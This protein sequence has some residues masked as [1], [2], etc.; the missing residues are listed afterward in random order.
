M[1]RK[2]L[3]TGITAFVIGAL[4]TTSLT[5]QQRKDD[6]LR[7]MDEFIAVY[8]K[9]RANYVDKVDDEQLMKGAIQGMLNT[10]DPHSAFLDES[11]FRDLQTQIE[12]EYGGLGL[13]VTQEDGAVKVIAPTADTPSTLPAS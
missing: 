9:V 12:G 6:P 1:Y 5:A 8:K 13:S 10:L 3:A 2:T 11:N 7:D 4:A